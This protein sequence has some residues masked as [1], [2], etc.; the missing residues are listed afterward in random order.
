MTV[1]ENKNNTFVLRVR[2]TP[3]AA[4]CKFNG[5]YNDGVCEWLKINVC[6]LPEKGKANRAL[7][8]F[9]AKEL[10]I[11]KSRIIIDSGKTDRCKILVIAIENDAEKIGSILQEKAGDDDSPDN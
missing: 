5:V 10:K 3:N 6:S 4:L 7:I 11:A 2:L 9:L 8:K 1:W